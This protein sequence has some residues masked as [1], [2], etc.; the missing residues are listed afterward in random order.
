MHIL[1]YFNHAGGVGKSSSVRDQGY[2]LSQRGFSVLL[3]DA[4]PQ[5][6]LSEWL[7]L[8]N[9]VE[10]AQTV[11]PAVIENF[12]SGDLRLPEPSR[13][14]GLELIPSQLDIA[15]LD[16]LLVGEF[17]GLVRLKNA[18][19][20]LEKYDFVLIDPPPSLGQ[21]SSLCVIAATKIV[22]PVPTNSK[23]LRGIGTVVSMVKRY[24]ELNPGLD[25]AM[26]LPTQYDSRTRH[27]RDSL[28]AIEQQ[29][30][31][32]ATVAPPLHNRPAVYK[33]AQ[34]AGAPVPVYRPSDP[35][36]SEI[37]A[38]TDALLK[39]LRMEVKG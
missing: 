35:A 32:Y 21:L 18:V 29:L 2:T 36:S 17:N 8:Q 24:Q 19:R 14:H 4:D 37:A 26:F 1:T 28:Q 11:F 12:G 7:G 9:E 25:I 5:A 34:I 16:Q 27:D 30:S 33:D 10:L 6:N 22:V 39:A 31:G 3:I 15:R 38:A 20:K 23:G 13:L